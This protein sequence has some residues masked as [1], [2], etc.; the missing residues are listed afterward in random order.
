MSP[1]SLLVRRR[2]Q[3]GFT[4][5]ELMVALAI[6]LI[7]ALAACMALL[8]AQRG[9]AAVDS[10]SR[11]R[12]NARFAAELIE[13]LALQAGYQDLTS[14]VDTR[15][16]AQS[17]LSQDPAPDIMGWDNAVISGLGTGSLSSSN[18]SRPA[19]CASG[20]GTA[21]ANGSDVLQLRFYGS[22]D[23]SGNADGSIIDCA[24]NAQKTIP[25]ND[26]SK[27][28]Y[29]VFYVDV[30]GQ[31]PTLMCAYLDPASNTFKSTPLVTG[32]ESFQ[33]LYGMD[34]VSASGAL[35]AA[36]GAPQTWLRADQISAGTLTATQ[37]NANWRRV[38]RIRIGMVLRGPPRAAADTT[39]GVYAPLGSSDTVSQLNVTANDGRVRQV[40][41]MT[42]ALRNPLNVCGSSQTD[43]GTSG[44][45]VCK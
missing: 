23:A 9:Y 10:S 22:S 38:R 45:Q 27:R 25:Y 24:G 42:I 12:E 17:F 44:S 2:S 32:V 8:A 7:V 35:S 36:S 16:E 33:V 26:V 5:V 19:S 29:S 39:V 13:R 31:E 4:L 6:S 43:V 3:R 40:I 15:Q 11:L 21:C 28:A 14:A 1:P 30:Q 18:G 20:S 34:G 37:I 41:S